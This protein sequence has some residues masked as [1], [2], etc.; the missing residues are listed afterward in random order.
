MAALTLLSIAAAS[1]E[2][3]INFGSRINATNVQSG[4]EVMDPSFE[5]QLGTFPSGF[6][7]SP[8]NVHEW[9]D[10]WVPLAPDSEGAHYED[11]ILSEDYAINAFSGSVVLT[12][13]EAPFQ[14]GG[15]VY[16]WGF[17]SKEVDVPFEWVLI[18]NPSWAWPVVDVDTVS[19]AVAF[20]LDDPGTFAV[21][22]EVHG[23]GFQ[24]QTTY[25]EDLDGDGVTNI[26]EL[27]I[28]NTNPFEADS[29]GDGVTDY[30]EDADGDGSRDGAE[31]AMGSDPVDAASAPVTATFAEWQDVKAGAG[32]M[33]TANDDGDPWVD[34]CEYAFGSNP[35]TGELVFAL[36][37]TKPAG[38]SF[39]LQN[40]TEVVA[41]YYRPGTDPDLMYVLQVSHDLA[42]WTTISL[43]PVVTPNAAGGELVTYTGLESDENPLV[44]LNKG[45]ARLA[46]SLISTG[47]TCYTETFGWC[48]VPL[49]N[50]YQTYGA[51]WLKK[52]F[53]AGRAASY[54]DGKI[55]VAS[56]SLSTWTNISNI[57]EQDR[58]YYLEFT[59][60]AY[61]GHRLEID[62]GATT[63]NE[64]GIE[65]E[66][67]AAHTVFPSTLSL[68]GDSF[69]LREHCWLGEI[70]EPIR[71]EGSNESA[72]SDQV[73]FFRDGA[74]DQLFLLKLGESHN[75]WSDS[76]FTNRNRET[77]RAGEGMF[78][79]GYGK[80]S[81]V[82][83]VGIGQVRTNAFAQPLVPGFQMIASGYP[84]DQSP[85]A[86]GMGGALFTGDTESSL[87]DQI[88]TW[89]GDTVPGESG[90]DLYFLL[91]LAPGYQFWSDSSFVDRGSESLF[92]ACRA[93]FLNKQNGQET[94]TLSLPW[95]P[96][97]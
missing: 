86:R 50:G 51:T 74:F 79:K 83:I 90:F 66:T 19:P 68:S 87:A 96:D 82:S 60:G 52:P 88:L 55:S 11:A 62:E 45:F 75:Y 23:D 26:Q 35:N 49:R 9:T 91:E 95:D 14:P 27:T 65:S 70:F 63:A 25:P 89:K 67:Y 12:E 77:V 84:L 47:E 34:L 40:N 10:E 64:L 53:F 97:S 36:D 7:P 31:I 56:S 1:G 94:F 80:T 20:S 37:P 3:S 92:K 16:I 81:P 57:L 78:F 44:S 28:L 54:S 5:F 30:D 33:V 72:I 58:Q 76:T 24:I 59:G 38:L 29:D 6:E 13:N 85:N 39:A 32:E 41:S 8:S 69:I 43:S 18:S 61:E 4:G 21:I 46:I 22:G 48:E 17:N 42:S 2:V 93:I 15:K 73:A 71:F